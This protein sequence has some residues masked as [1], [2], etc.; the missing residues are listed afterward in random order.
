MDENLSGMADMAAEV[1]ELRSRIA[2]GMTTAS[3][4]PLFDFI[5]GLTKPP[6]RPEPN[7]NRADPFGP[8][9]RN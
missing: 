6:E 7:L 9:T 8:P 4:L 1:G 2:S 5:A 3:D